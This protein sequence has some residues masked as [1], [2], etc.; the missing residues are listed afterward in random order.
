MTPLLKKTGAD[1]ADMSNFRPVSNVSFMSKIVERAVAIQL[2]EYLSAN[3][4]F[5]RLQSAYRK[6]HSTETALLR[7]WSDILEAA[8]EQR[9]TLLAMLDLSAAFDCV[10]HTILLQRLQLGY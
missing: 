6:R 5:S 8:D 10:D 4:L 7:V 9:A 2:T 3:D 1:P